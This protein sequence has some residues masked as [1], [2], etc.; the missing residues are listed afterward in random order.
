MGGLSWVCVSTTLAELQ[1]Q[2]Y[3]R[4]KPEA[5]AAFAAELAIE[6]LE[7]KM[8]NSYAQAFA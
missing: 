7:L 5:R 2:V 3:A 6:A 4:K 8:R 1:R